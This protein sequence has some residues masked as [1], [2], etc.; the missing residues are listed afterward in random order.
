MA[1]TAEERKQLK[2]KVSSQKSWFTRISTD[3]DKVAARFGAKPSDEGALTVQTFSAKLDKMY[4][5]LQQSVADYNEID[6]DE[7][8]V[9]ALEA[10]ADAA[11]ASYGKIKDGVDRLLKKYFEQTKGPRVHTSDS[12]SYQNQL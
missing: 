4:L 10:Y 1:I 7:T 6:D 9:A 2:T 8:A 3:T 11:Q 5:A 12:S